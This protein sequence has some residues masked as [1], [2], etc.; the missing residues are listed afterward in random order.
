MQVMDIGSA[1]GFFSLPMAELV[2]ED[3]RAICVDIQQKMLDSLL[4]RARRAD[5]EHRIE[6]RLSSTDSL[7]VSD[8]GG[9]ID[10]ALAFAVVHEA[11]N[12]DRLFADVFTA[13]KPGG[14]V[15]FAEPKGHVKESAFRKSTTIA[16][17]EGF[18]LIDTP[19]IPR[20]HAVV[21]QNQKNQVNSDE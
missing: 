11:A 13:L 5:L 2:G 7:G 14:R 3:G 12:P 9:Q 20:S 19:N 17:A 16:E 15:L 10:F 8:L 1:M 21:L 18:Q 4:R 6:T